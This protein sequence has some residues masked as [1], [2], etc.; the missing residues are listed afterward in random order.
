[1]YYVPISPAITN[2]NAPTDVIVGFDTQIY[3]VESGANRVARYNISGV[4]QDYSPPILRPKAIAMD[5]K[6]R[7]YVTG[8]VDTTITF[9]GSPQHVQIAALYRLDMV[10]GGGQLSTTTPQVIF[11]RLEPVTSF[12]DTLV[13]FTGVATLP[14][15]SFFLTRKGPNTTSFFGADNNI[16]K[17]SSDLLTISP[18]THD[19]GLQ[20]YP[21]GTAAYSAYNITSIVTNCQPPQQNV[22]A[23]PGNFYYTLSGDSTVFIK[24]QSIQVVTDPETQSQEYGYYSYRPTSAGTRY[25]SDLNRFKNPTDITIDG[26]TGYIFVVDA[27]TDSVF[28]FTGNGIEGVPP[29]AGSGLTKN[30]I[31]S[32]GGAGSDGMHFKNPQGVASYNK[33]LYVADTGNNR[34]LSFK[35]STDLQ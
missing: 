9:N 17:F 13:Q 24:A 12:N 30:I 23:N 3:V 2:L 22:P 10:A 35:L 28:Q 15:N 29:P 34:V 7:L 31:V 25:F 21:F 6:M 8:Y 33:T 20:F 26:N 1:M 18:I 27:G 16:L 19:G 14:D 11:T 4:L 5:R 32:F